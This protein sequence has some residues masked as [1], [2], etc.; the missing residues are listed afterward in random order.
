MIY[1]SKE[2]GSAYFNL[3]PA[4]HE[5]LKAGKPVR[6][7]TGD[8]RGQAT[9]TIQM[10]RPDTPEKRFPYLSPEDARKADEEGKQPK[11]SARIELVSDH[12]PKC[13][14][15]RNECIAPDCRRHGRGI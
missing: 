3:T 12:C 14:D 7:V 4:E 5:T 13:V 9:I 6:K 1:G 11:P 2:D 8:R 15:P 10:V